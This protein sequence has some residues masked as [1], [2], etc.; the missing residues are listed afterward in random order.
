MAGNLNALHMGG[1]GANVRRQPQQQQL[2]Q[3]LYSHIMTQPPPTAGWQTAVAPQVRVGNALN[4]IT[5]SILAMPQSDNNQAV[6][7][8]LGY[9][10]DAFTASTDKIA[11]DSRI[12][13]RLGDLF[14][15]R[16][17]NE[18]S[19]HSGLNAQAAAQAQ[20]RSQATMIM[21]QNM[22]MRGM[23][24]PLQQGLQ[25]IPQ[26]AQ[27]PPPPSHQGQPNM[28]VGRPNNMPLNAGN[29]QM[30]SIGGQVRP[31]MTGANPMASLSP[32]DQMKVNNLAVAKVNQMPEQQRQQFRAM[33]T[34]RLGRDQLA[35][36]QQE[37]LDPLVYYFQH[38]IIQ[39]GMR[40]Q[41]AGAMQ[42]HQNR[43]M[44]QPAQQQAPT[45]P[46]GTFSPFSNVEILNQQKAGLMAQE[47]GQMVVPASSVAGRNATPQPMGGPTGPNQGPG[48]PPQPAHGPFNPAQATQQQMDQRAAETQSQ[49][50]V[51]AQANQMQ[52]QPGALSGPGGI[53]QSPAMN[54]LN[55]PVRRPMAGAQVEGHHPQMG[56]ANIPFGQPLMD[57]RFNQMG[58]RP[59]MG[60]NAGVNRQMLTNI[61]NQMPPEIQQ[62]IMALPQD[63][64][65]E[66]IL[67]WNASRRAAQMPGRP[68]PQPGQLGPG[69]N[70]I[71]QP[72]G[73]FSPGNSG[74]NQQ[75]AMGIPTNPQTQAGIQ[76]QVKF[77]NPNSFQQPPDRVA[78]MDNMGLPPKMLDSVRAMPN[79]P[80]FPMDIKKWGQLK[81]WMSQH[82]LPAN[83]VQYLS[84]VQ[85]AQ[86]NNYA[87]K[88]LGAANSQGPQQN[89]QQQPQMGQQTLNNMGAQNPPVQVTPQEMQAAR[90]HDRFKNI[91]DDK[92]HTILAH[93][94]MQNMMKGRA[95]PQAQPP[96][97]KPSQPQPSP[98]PH[99]AG[100]ALQTQGPQV[101]QP[102]SI[103]TAATS[104]PANGAVGPPRPSNAGPESGPTAPAMAPSRSK[105]QAPNNRAPPNA[106]GPPASKVGT[107]RPNSDDV[108]E[109]P[110]P[111]STPVQRTA[112]QQAQSGS[113]GPRAPFFTPEQVAALPPEQRQRYEAI[114]RNRQTHN[115]QQIVEGMAR[116]K[117]IGQE[118]L[119]A[120]SREQLPDIPMSPEQYRDTAQKIQ[121]MCTEMTKVSKILGRWFSLTR[122]EARAAMF[123]K[124][125][126][127]LLK[128]YAD[129][130]SL[131]TLRN[132]FSI[133]PGDLDAMR[134]ML[135]SMVADVAN[136][137][138]SMRKTSSQQNAQET[139]APHPT[140]PPQPTPLNAANLEKQTQA[141]NKAHHQKSNSKV[142]Q[143]PAA[144]TTAQPPF[145]FGAQSPDGQPKYA[146]KPAVTQD[147]LHLPARK[148]ARTG[149]AP[150]MN[151]SSA[152]ASPQ[153]QKLA[154]PEMA[155]R[156]A[157]TET[158]PPAPKPQ[159]LCTEQACEFHTI[160]FPNENAQRKHM[161]DEHMK[162]AEDPMKFASE[163]LAEA[164]GLD[165]NG[166]PKNTNVPG[167]NVQSP[168]DI[169]KQQSQASPMGPN[170]PDLA[171]ARSTPMGRQASAAGSKPTDLL[172]T[173]AGKVGTPK[174]DANPVSSPSVGTGPGPQ[175]TGFGSMGMTID[176]QDLF[177]IPGLDMG[178]GGAISD[179]HLYRSLTPNDTPESIKDS[180]T[181]EP[182]SD[183]S[184]GVALNL[185]LDMGIGHWDPFAGGKG[186]D[187]DGNL[188]MGDGDNMLNT[189]GAITWE[190]VNP[191]FDKPFV[192]DTS[193]FSLDPS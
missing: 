167:S 24:Q 148:K 55:A 83:L 132:R 53:S 42:P 56:Q 102:G 36:L 180:A 77:R 28:G 150:N 70:P 177:R 145:P 14:K 153:V 71:G 29:P 168:G 57:S 76:Q 124:M 92:L 62:Q 106:S 141:L 7:L 178:A 166:K 134:S 81:N 140:A 157:T 46:N 86:Y 73:Q 174:A 97:P 152:N 130:E 122:D 133:T 40:N 6:N 179:M 113:T 151:G 85:N 181:S 131:T 47:A 147:T 75:P 158:K 80:D 84:N 111:S 161:E 188:D 101:S 69:G 159:F 154:S 117:A 163:N 3:L 45:G 25:P 37:G 136:H 182:N 176:P 63:K 32:Q 121:N 170:R 186:M 19:I 52:G 22:Q 164:L 173:I 33:V 184:E 66:M 155:K 60:P 114:V 189:Y 43:A 44:N 99:A 105:Q 48:M 18:Q 50:R 127:R 34:N 128:Q 139:T 67:K 112:S 35:H 12:A 72:M 135:E 68:Q 103:P 21:N 5:N 9:E 175:A 116:L 146:G 185:T 23:A 144:P 137:F 2:S 171:N 93:M 191:N 64:V 1:A 98:A 61:M 26:Q 109:V 160:G 193:L 51:Q 8:G 65:P 125:R 156:P 142:G 110:D 79:A 10:R 11:Y 58:Q 16:Q 165:S 39:Q 27:P 162:P 95:G 49:I 88:N 104:Q 183:V 54:N 4:I 100:Q 172:K 169:S 190:D 31:Q 115:Q 123:F 118:Q 87:N 38:Q 138:P 17:A 13:A 120:S 96:Q 90:N 143:P 74:V 20:A 187:S 82:Q 107:K 30:M 15:K 126:L 129:G 192:I 89:L 78:V 59:A 108:T 94:K 41:Q 119:Q 149:G 91:P